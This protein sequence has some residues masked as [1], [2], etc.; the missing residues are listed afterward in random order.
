MFEAPF[1][2]SYVEMFIALGVWLNTTI[3]VYNFMK[4]KNDRD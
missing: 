3:N 1:T 2:I 4:A